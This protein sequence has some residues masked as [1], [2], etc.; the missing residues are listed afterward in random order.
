MEAREGPGRFQWSAGSWFGAQIGATLW[1]PLLGVL[2]LAQGRMA[3]ALVLGMALAVNGMGLFLWSRRGTWEPYPAVQLLLGAS[4]VAALIS[5]LLA[6]PAPSPGEGFELAPSLPTL[7]VYPG[8][9]LVVYLQERSA[10][11]SDD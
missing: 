1:M 3:G 7:L 2:M 8:L 4:A 11:N 10:R 9:M 5:V 6:S